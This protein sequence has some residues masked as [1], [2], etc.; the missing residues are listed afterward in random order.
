MKNYKVGL[1]GFGFIG[2]VH[3]FGYRNMPL[4]YN[5]DDFSARVVKVC[6]SRPETAAKAAELTGAEGVT[7]FRAI[8][9]DPSIDIV[10]IASPNDC[11]FAE[12][13]SAMAANKHIYCD[14]PLTETADEARR[15]AD[16]L[17]AYKGIAQMTLMYRFY[18]AVLRAKELI[19][20]GKIGRILEFHAS[21]LHSGSVSEETPYKWKLG[22]GTTAD[23]GSHIFDL[24]QFIAGPVTAL[25]AKTWIAHPERKD[26]YDPSKTVK[27]T[28]DDSMHCLV[29]LA[30]GGVGTVCASK[31]AT[32]TEDEV[33]FTIHG[34][35]GALKM[36]PMNLQQLFYYD[37]T[38]PDT[39]HGG[40]RGWTAIDCGARFGGNAAFP[41]P[42]AV[43]GWMRGH[44]H[45]LHHFLEAVHSKTMPEPSLADGIRLQILL[46][47]VKESARTGCW[48]KI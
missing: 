2:K 7:D 38:A 28:G 44:V 41:A 30:D 27:I 4:Y 36:E 34:T 43:M 10:D 31:I 11:H 37:N 45:C 20:A 26:F 18:P 32:G 24:L 1:I 17:P 12:L 8:T 46:D 22:S 13:A 9:E 21:F 3:E 15:I 23:L 39:P 29:Q 48:V 40:F 6:T 42:K 33:S 35:K 19:E 16:L 5:G 25:T 47:K 14:K